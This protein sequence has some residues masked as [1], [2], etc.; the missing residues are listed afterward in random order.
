MS[1]MHDGLTGSDDLYNPQLLDAVNDTEELAT[2]AMDFSPGTWLNPLPGS[3]ND[4]GAAVS[5][6]AFATADFDCREFP[7]ISKVEDPPISFVDV[8]RSQYQDVWNDS[9]YAESSGLWN[10]NAFRRLK[11][12]ELPKNANVV[13][14]K[15]VRNWKTD[16]RGNVIKP[17]SRMVARGLARFKT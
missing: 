17:K 10:S 5:E 7:H 2:S 8:E 11:K 3:R 1:V 6:S 12:G 15:W 13:T 14:G 4:Y 16:D 9:G